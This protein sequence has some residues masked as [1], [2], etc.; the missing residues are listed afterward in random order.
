ML[1]SIG[2]LF[3]QS[4]ASNCQHRLIN[5]LYEKESFLK[6]GNFLQNGTTIATPP[7]RANQISPPPCTLWLNLLSQDLNKF[8]IIKL[9]IIWHKQQKYPLLCFY[10]KIMLYN[11][12]TI[13]QSELALYC[14]HT[15]GIVM[16]I[17]NSVLRKNIVLPCYEKLWRDF[18]DLEDSRIC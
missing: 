18:R 2:N 14:L 9:F 1:H 7:P 4:F 16:M 17:L 15:K 3:V 12:V 6:C 10:R 13:S 11:S 8:L 5:F